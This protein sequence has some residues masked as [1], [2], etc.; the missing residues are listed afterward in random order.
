M[1]NNGP[2]PP[3]GL[4]TAGRR[5]W[6]EVLTDYDLEQHELLL[7]R[8]ACRVSDRL[9]ELA[10]LVE[11]DGAVVDSPQGERAHPAL[12]E[13]RQQ[14]ITL[15]RVLAA[16]RLPAGEE[17]DQASGRRPQRRVGVRGVY[18]VSGVA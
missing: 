18:G 11:R 2:K 13:S 1:T 10:A 15:A 12:V 3:E 16:L 7:L 5:L 8:E 4:K 6:R 9:D 14:Q 17:G